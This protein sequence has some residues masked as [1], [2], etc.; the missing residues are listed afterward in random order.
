M[1]NRDRRPPSCSRSTQFSSLRQSIASS[2]P[3][4]A[5]AGDELWARKEQDWL[6]WSHSDY[7]AAFAFAATEYGHSLITPR[8]GIKGG[9][10]VEG[11]VGVV[12]ESIRSLKRFLPK[13]TVTWRGRIGRNLD[14]KMGA[15]PAP[16]ATAGRIN[17]QGEPVLYLCF[18]ELTPVFEV[19]PSI[20]DIVSV[21]SS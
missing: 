10:T 12:R 19:R 9:H 13:G 8:R 3:P 17:K 5:G 15:P 1:V 20:G 16:V 2:W 4:L 21:Q 11:A 18:D 14:G 7:Y 6:H